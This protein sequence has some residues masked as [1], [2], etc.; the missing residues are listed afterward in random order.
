MADWTFIQQGGDKKSLRLSGAFAPHG[1]ARQKPVVTDGIELRSERFYYPGNSV[2]TRHVFGSKLEDFELEGRFSD[3]DAGRGGAAKKVEEVKS[4]LHDAQPVLITWGKLITGTGMLKSFSPSRESFGNVAWKLVVEVDED[5]NLD[6]A[7]GKQP[8][9]EK[10]ADLTKQLRDAMAE[11]FGDRRDQKSITTFPPSIDLGLSDTLD[12]L[13]SAVNTPVAWFVNLSNQVVDLERATVGSI[14]RLRAGLHQAKTA[15]LNLRA[16]YEDASGESS[17][18]SSSSDAQA[19]FSKRQCDTNAAIIASL[20]ALRKLDRACAVAER[21]MV[22][23]I[24]TARA[25]D[26]WESIAKAAAGSASKAASIQEA[27]AVSGLP[28]PGTKYVIPR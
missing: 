27:N 23:S 4:F 25:G 5:L 17:L 13:V 20:D 3:A 12:S 21:K 24:W 10:L 11:A 8:E 7:S 28:N 14:K 19:Q 18:V 26:T 6:S 9:P 15:T 22:R 2:P 16:A 1:R